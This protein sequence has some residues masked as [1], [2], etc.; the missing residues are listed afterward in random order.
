MKFYHD[1]PNG[2]RQMKKHYKWTKEIVLT[3][4]M[5]EDSNF[6]HEYTAKL[7]LY[8]HHNSNFGASKEHKGIEIDI[9]DDWELRALENEEGLSVNLTQKMINIIERKLILQDLR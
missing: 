9:L 6:P 5:D 2:E 1:I 4:L 7:L 8:C 3:F